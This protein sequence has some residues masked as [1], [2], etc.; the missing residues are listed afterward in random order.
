[1]TGAVSR[2][3]QPRLARVFTE[4]LQLCN[5]EDGAEVEKRARTKLVGIHFAYLAGN[6]QVTA[7]C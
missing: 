6:S 3:V 2:C 4:M 1:M 7:A 5:L